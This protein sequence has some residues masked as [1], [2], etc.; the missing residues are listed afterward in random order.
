MVFTVKLGQTIYPLCYIQPYKVSNKHQWTQKD[1]DLQ[2]LHLQ[3]Q[4]PNLKNMEVIFARSIIRRVMVFP[5]Y[6]QSGQKSDDHIVFDILDTDMF[7][8]TQEYFK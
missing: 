3:K 1:K 4:K 6:T 8:R 7:L 2:L 5:A